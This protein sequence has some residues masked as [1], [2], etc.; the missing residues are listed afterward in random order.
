MTFMILTKFQFVQGERQ[1]K[2]IFFSDALSNNQFIRF[3]RGTC[4]I[5]NCPFSHKIL[6]DKMPTCTYFLRGLCLRND[7]PYS[8]VN[9][10][11]NAEVCQAFTDGHCSLGSEV[12]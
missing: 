5:S 11:R 9:V 1:T 10:G 2:I 3:L 6:K 7:C 8:H 12:T 4:S